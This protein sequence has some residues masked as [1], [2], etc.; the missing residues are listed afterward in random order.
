MH[1]REAELAKSPVGSSEHLSLT[2]IQS[3]E[4]LED[5]TVKPGST[6]ATYFRGSQGHRQTL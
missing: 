3:R 4:A 1:Y 2:P 6:L 5:I